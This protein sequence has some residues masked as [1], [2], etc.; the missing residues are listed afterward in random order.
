VPYVRPGVRAAAGV[1]RP[2][3]LGQRGTDPSQQIVSGFLLRSRL[4]TEYPNLGVYGYEK[5]HTPNQGPNTA[6]MTILRMERLGDHSDILLC[7]FDGDAY[8]VDI[9]EAPEHLHYGIDGYA[10]ENGK[11]TASKNLRSLPRTAIRRPFPKPL[12][13]PR[14]I[15]PAVSG[16]PRPAP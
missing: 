1:L 10:Y 7:L 3:G 12:S 2:K 16:P 15:S 14:P 4:V 6:F 13:S 11:V 5:G 9:H 8:R